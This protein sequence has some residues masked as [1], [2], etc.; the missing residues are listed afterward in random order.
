MGQSVTKGGGKGGKETR[1]NS[2]P[3][4]M[5]SLRAS[6][7]AQ[8]SFHELT[9]KTFPFLYFNTMTWQYTDAMVE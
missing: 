7:Y 2:A 3:A 4:K 9:H 1:L 6:K 8:T 5:P